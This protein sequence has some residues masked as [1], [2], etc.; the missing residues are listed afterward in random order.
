MPCVKFPE[1]WRLQLR[2][3]LVL[4]FARD[5]VLERSE[6]FVKS[7]TLRKDQYGLKTFMECYKRIVQVASLAPKGHNHRVQTSNQ[8]GK[9]DEKCTAQR[10]WD[11]KPPYGLT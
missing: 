1:V 5:N 7:T 4:R 8:V 10:V 2:D 6:E 3:Y 11:F 9:R